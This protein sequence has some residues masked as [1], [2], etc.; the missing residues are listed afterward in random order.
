METTFT[1]QK[2][3]GIKRW[4]CSKIREIESKFYDDHRKVQ[5]YWIGMRFIDGSKIW[6]ATSAALAKELGNLPQE[7]TKDAKEARA[8]AVKDYFHQHLGEFEVKPNGH[9]LDENGE[10]T[11]E[12]MWSISAIEAGVDDDL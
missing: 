6:A 8:K 2:G 12:I 10:E 1:I 5:Y 9:Y 3:A 7:D 11:P 4:S